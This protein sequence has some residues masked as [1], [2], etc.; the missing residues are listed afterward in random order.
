[1]RRWMVLVLALAVTGMV[2]EAVAQPPK[3]RLT[4]IQEHGV[5]RVGTS[6]DFKP[7]SYKDPAT[8]EYR[9]YDIDAAKQLAADLGVKLEFVP[10]AWSNLISGLLAD[11]FDIAMSGTSMTLQRA[12]SV[13]FSD[14]YNR[15]GQVPLIRKENAGKFKTWEDLDQ[16]AVTVAVQLGTLADKVVTDNLKKATIRKIDA[17]ARDYQELIANR[18]QAVVTSNIESAALIAE[19]NN[20]AMVDPAHPKQK[21]FHAYLVPQGDQVWLNYVNYWVT[22]RHLDGFFAALQEKYLGQVTYRP[23]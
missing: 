18:V 16:P 19:Y 1:M 8:G 13:A 12:K 9:G 10:F 21:N 17:P 22:Q 15:L 7:M 3:S 6:G 20:L 14:P 11:K 5:L 23:Y 4:L 2:G